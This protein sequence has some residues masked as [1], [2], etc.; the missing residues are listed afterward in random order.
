VIL[1]QTTSE[2]SEIILSCRIAFSR[3]S[4][5][6]LAATAVSWL[7]QRGQRH[8]RRLRL[9]AAWKRHETS[10]YRFFSRF[11][12]RPKLFFRALLALIVQAFGL[13]KLLIVVDDTICPT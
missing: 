6:Y 1:Y 4:W 11:K 8:I 5:P 13:S 10:F 9:G 3:R 7:I 12:F 2:F